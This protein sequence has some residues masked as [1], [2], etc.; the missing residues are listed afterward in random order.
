MEVN[1]TRPSASSGSTGGFSIFGTVVHMTA[2]PYSKPH[3]SFDEQLALLES[4]GLGVK[5]R[6]AALRLLGAAGYYTLGGYL[7]PMR[8]IVNG[9]RTERFL[10]GATFEHLNDLYQFDRRLRLLCLDA[11]EIIER[12]IKVRVAYELGMQDKFAHATGSLHNADFLRPRPAGRPSEHNEWINNHNRKLKDRNHEAV[13][14]FINKYG[15]PL[16][17]WV[18]IDV[19]DFGDISKLVGHLSRRQQ[20]ALAPHFG[21]HRGLDFAAWT[22]SMCLVRNFAAHHSRLWNRDLPDRPTKPGDP[23]LLWFADVVEDEWRW[24]RMYTALLVIAFVLT[25][26]E[27][28]THWPA[29]VGSLLLTLPEGYGV[30][31]DGLGAPQHWIDNS[32]WKLL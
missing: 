31:Y 13:P 28:G 21:I 7:Y 3:L 23:E 14:A 6:D 12:A 8:E 16:P 1:T 30:T 2:V 19:M 18:A 25:H 24:G 4:R 10:P 17:I 11:L 22:R 20:S 26:L 5:D 9:E 15:T 27:P 32:L 29:A